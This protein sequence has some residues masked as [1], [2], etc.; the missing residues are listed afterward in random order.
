MLDHELVERGGANWIVLV[1]IDQE[2][3]TDHLPIGAE[4]A[5][6]DPDAIVTET[7]GMSL[8]EC[9]ARWGAAGGLPLRK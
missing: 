5:A 3:M 6:G 7:A 8:D 1:G 4:R 2:A 9:R